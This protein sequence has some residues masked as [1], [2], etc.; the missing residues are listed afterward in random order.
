MGNHVSDV[1]DP[2]CA[3]A[4]FHAQVVIVPDDDVRATREGH[5]ALRSHTGIGRFHTVEVDV[6]V[7]PIAERLFAGLPAAT[8]DVCFLGLDR[9]SRLPR[10]G[11]PM[12]GHDL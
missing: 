3:E 6:V 12:L 4:R 11:L 9:L 7:R 5:P 1:R 2:I 10:K 8:Q